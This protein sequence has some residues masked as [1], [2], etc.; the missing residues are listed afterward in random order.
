MVAAMTEGES[1]VASENPFTKPLVDR[2]SARRR[3]TRLAVQFDVDELSFG[4]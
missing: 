2:D 4:S 3:A 1:G